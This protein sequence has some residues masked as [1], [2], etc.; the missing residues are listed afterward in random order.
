MLVYDHEEV[1]CACYMSPAITRTPCLESRG[2]AAA[3]RITNSV[4]EIV[5]RVARITSG[6]PRS[7]PASD[8]SSGLG[9]LCS[10]LESVS[11][12]PDGVDSTG[13]IQKYLVR[14]SEQ[15]R[16]AEAWH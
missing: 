4:V 6:V 7:K 8:V 10:V 2:E 5:R 1:K 12:G 15:R 14:G 13:I 3:E 16:T 9:Q 11:K